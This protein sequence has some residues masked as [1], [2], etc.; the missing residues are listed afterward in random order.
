MRYIVGSHASLAVYGNYQW[1]DLA[2]LKIVRARQRARLY[3]LQGMKANT[4][5]NFVGDAYSCRRNARLSYKARE[6]QRGCVAL[7]GDEGGG[8]YEDGG[9]KREWKRDGITVASARKRTNFSRMTR[10]I[11]IHIYI[12]IYICIY[13][14]IHIYMY[15]SYVYCFA[16]VSSCREWWSGAIQPAIIANSCPES[17]SRIR[18]A[19]TPS[20][21]TRETVI[22]SSILPTTRRTIPVTRNSQKSPL[23]ETRRLRRKISDSPT[24]GATRAIA[25]ERFRGLRKF[26]TSRRVVS[27]YADRTYS[28][29]T[30]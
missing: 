17:N 25:S 28:E 7:F 3:S 6:R 21:R 8:G 4:E 24:P 10:Y 14:Y 12:Y 30:G 29:V 5:I 22:V 13:I 2:R 1:R 19:H 27:R 11:Y 16:R 23:P 20:A 18:N 15:W 9:M 26:A